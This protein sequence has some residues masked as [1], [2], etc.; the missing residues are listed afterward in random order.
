MTHFN[1]GGET[2]E[3]NILPPPEPSYSYFESG[4]SKPPVGS[5]PQFTPPKNTPRWRKA[6]LWTGLIV[7]TL[8]LL[9]LMFG[10]KTPGEDNTNAQG[11]NSAGSVN[12]PANPDVKPGTQTWKQVTTLTGTANKRSAPFTVTSERTRLVYKVTDPN[13]TDAVLVAV[14]LMKQG[15]SLTES[16]GFAEVTIDGPIRDRT[17]LSRSPGSYYLDVAS[18]NA[19]WVV[20]V[21]ELR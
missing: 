12:I 3:G 9:S 17:E 1:R 14:Y 2:N 11:S 6:L 19:T 21:E 4:G 16:G 5:R 13:R 20:T 15:T 18:A 7:V 8:F 10:T